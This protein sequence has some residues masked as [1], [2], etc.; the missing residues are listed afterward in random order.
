[1]GLVERRLRQV[2]VRLRELREELRVV[3]EQL[4]HL[5]DEADDLGLRALVAETPGAGVEHREAQLHADAMSRH[6]AHV[7]ASIAELEQR[8][9]QLLDRLA[10]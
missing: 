10:P 1:V 8:Q 2:S 9:D 5:A 7:V 3:D 6:R 4:A